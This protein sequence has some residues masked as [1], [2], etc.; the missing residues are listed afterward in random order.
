M[1]EE[2]G[3]GNKL[4]EDD[5]DGDE[6]GATAGSV[7]NGDFEASAF[8]ILIA[9]AESDAAFG[10]IFT[11]GDFFLKAATANAGEDASFHARAISARNDT[12]LERLA[13]AG[14]NFGSRF[15]EDF[16]PNG[17]SITEFAQTRDAFAA[18]EG[19][20]FQLVEIDNFAALAKAALHEHAGEG[21]FSFGRGWEFNVPEVGAGIEEVDGIKE[22]F[23]FLVNFGHDAGT[24]GFDLIA[25]E[26]AFKSEFLMLKE[27][28]LEAE[29]PPI[30]ADKEGLGHL[31]DQD[32]AGSKPRDFE[33]HA[34][35]DA[36][37]LTHGF[38]CASGGHGSRN[39]FKIE[40]NTGNLTDLEEWYRFVVSTNNAG[41][42][43]QSAQ[44][45]PACASGR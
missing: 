43:G 29:D 23:G 3:A 15:G 4:R 45:Q 6:D 25:F 44:E 22:A 35:G 8:G 9:A 11:D 20:Q 31:L 34:K 26:L 19:S 39:G 1:T 7:R 13:R 10:K 38:F 37:A 27:L 18:F 21:F 24:S 14:R 5:A 41:A 2:A 42:A 16:H 36:V 17:G 30:A 33:G 32:T 40:R 12:F 28:F